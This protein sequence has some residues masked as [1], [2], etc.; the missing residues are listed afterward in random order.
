MGV[1]NP[2]YVVY[3]IYASIKDTPSIKD[4]DLETKVQLESIVI[5]GKMAVLI[6]S[7]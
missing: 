3:V 1:S 5:Y 6:V 7:H 4:R 2:G